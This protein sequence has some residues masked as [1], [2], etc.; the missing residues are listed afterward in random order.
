MRMLKAE[1]GGQN[2]QSFKFSVD[3][4]WDGIR[5][6]GSLD[7]RQTRGLP[8]R[9]AS[10]LASPKWFLK[11]LKLRNKPI[12]WI[13]D[14]RFTMYEPVAA[15]LRHSRSG[16]PRQKEDT[17]KHAILR[18]EAKFREGLFFHQVAERQA[19]V[20]D[21]LSYFRRAILKNEANLSIYDLRLPI[22]DWASSRWPFFSRQGREESEVRN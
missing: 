7:L 10:T 2:G 14:L 20:R 21:Y 11:K 13:Y 8:L 1:F 4:L 6:A 12:L 15:L 17:I 3:D 5:E 16:L 18:N 22:C 19:I 9:L